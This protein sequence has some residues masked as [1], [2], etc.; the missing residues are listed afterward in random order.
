MLLALTSAQ[1]LTAG[2]AEMAYENNATEK[3]IIDVLN[4][5]S[6]YYQ[7]FFSYDNE[8][9][10]D[11]KVNFDIK[12]EEIFDHAI[13]RLMKET[14][15]DYTVYSNKYLVIFKNDSKG[16]KA[17][18]KMGKVIKEMEKLESEGNLSL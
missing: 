16:K 4:Q 9:L 15:F 14:V 12:K 10:K 2:T 8:L 11:V 17:A 1:F 6:E 3:D 7:V 18:K 5:M 13:K